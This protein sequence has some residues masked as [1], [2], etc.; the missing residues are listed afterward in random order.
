VDGSCL[1]PYFGDGLLGII[2]VP[3]DVLVPGGTMLLSRFFSLAS[4]LAMYALLSAVFVW[5]SLPPRLAVSL[6]FY[7]LAGNPTICFLHFC[8]CHRLIALLTRLTP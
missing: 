6:H 1:V 3:C 2:A 7:D 5:Y 4:L 8:G